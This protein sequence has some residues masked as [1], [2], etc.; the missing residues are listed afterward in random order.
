[1]VKVLQC[2]QTH[3]LLYT[4]DNDQISTMIPAKLSAVIPVLRF[5]GGKKPM[6]IS[7]IF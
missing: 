1:M 7:H 6:E 5:N 3:L 4:L 2:V